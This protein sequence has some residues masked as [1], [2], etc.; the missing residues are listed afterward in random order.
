MSG[1]HTPGPWTLTHVEGS[2]FAIQ[3]FEIRGMFGDQ[4][5]VYPIFNRSLSAIDG[6]TICVSP[7][8]ARLIAAA[9]EL[10][11]ALEMLVADFGGYPA[12]ERP[13]LAFDKARAAIAKATRS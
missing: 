2:N 9:P 12:S 7:Q 5:N 4:S 8:N 11:E 10:L 13:C 3:R 1:K 6:G